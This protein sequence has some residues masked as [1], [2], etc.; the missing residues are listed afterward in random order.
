MI[1]TFPEK[2]LAHS[3]HLCGG[4]L[5]RYRQGAKTP[6]TTKDGFGYGPTP[7]SGKSDSSRQ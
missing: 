7:H 3:L 4:Y 5:K 2:N 1:S 6:R